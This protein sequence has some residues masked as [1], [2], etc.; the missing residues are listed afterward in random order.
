LHTDPISN[1]LEENSGRERDKC[2]LEAYVRSTKPLLPIS[3]F[4][5]MIETP[6]LARMTVP[7]RVVREEINPT[8]DVALGRLRNKPGSGFD[9]LAGSEQ[10]DSSSGRGVLDMVCFAYPV[11]TALL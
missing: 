6:K 11:V 8:M 10:T 9:W 5:G 7:G 3:I 2:V 1:I 4:R